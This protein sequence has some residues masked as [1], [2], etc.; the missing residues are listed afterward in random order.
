[1]GLVFRRMGWAA[2]L[3]ALAYA[4]AAWG[5]V[6][7]SNRY[8]SLGEFSA[9]DPRYSA[10]VLPVAVLALVYLFTSTRQESLVSTAWR[11]PLP[12]WSRKAAALPLV[13]LAVAVTFS[14]LHTWS[15]MMND[16]ILT[17]PRTWVDNIKRTSQEVGAVSVLNGS[18]PANVVAPAFYPE[19][20]RISA[21]LSPLEH[22]LEFDMPSEEIYVVDGAGKLRA[23]E[24]RPASVAMPGPAG[25]CGYIVNGEQWTF[26]PMA[27]EL[28]AWN[29]GI[30]ISYMSTWPTVMEI[31]ALDQ[32]LIVSGPS[33]LRSVQA[34]LVSK[35]DVIALRTTNGTA[36]CVPS[37]LVGLLEPT[38][39]A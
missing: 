30:Q 3:M 12:S 36:V 13:G 20:G 35:V 9:L 22:D 6:V 26:V 32:S 37:I 17:S 39:P 21:I 34:V 23:A 19:A 38:G 15:I 25:D 1:V 7:G 28:H 8:R 10:D 31:R 4:A 5:L 27:Q 33:G 18:A 16:L 14:S 2:V 29:W 11:Y 24:I